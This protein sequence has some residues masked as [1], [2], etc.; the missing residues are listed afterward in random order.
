MHQQPALRDRGL[1]RDARLPVAERL[2]R[3]GLYLPSGTTLTAAQIEHVCDVLAR[4]L[5]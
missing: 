2:A 4:I 1:F 3:R 5:Q